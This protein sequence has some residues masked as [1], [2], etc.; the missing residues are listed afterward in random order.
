MKA[1]QQLIRTVEVHDRLGNV[2]GSK[3]VVLYAGL[4]SQAHEEGLMRVRT[5]ILQIP[6]EENSR[7][8]I[9]KAEVETSKGLFEA[10]GDARR[11]WLAI[12][13]HMADGATIEFQG[14]GR[15]RW[16]I[17]WQEGRV[18][19]EYVTE[20]IWTVNEEVTAPA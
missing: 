11:V 9:V 20:I 2:V 17:R 14:E 4:L 8:A 19:E 13:P 12:A 3:E 6:T 10:I 7:L 1:D 18:F 16:R 5:S 15:E